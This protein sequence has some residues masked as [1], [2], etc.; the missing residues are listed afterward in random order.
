MAPS[1]VAWDS[2]DL[3]LF[4]INFSFCGFV[5]FV[6]WSWSR[7][8]SNFKAHLAICC[9]LSGI[10]TSIEILLLWRSLKLSLIWNRLLYW[11]QLI[12]LWLSVTN[13]Q[14]WP[15]GTYC[16]HFHFLVPIKPAG[17][18]C[19]LLMKC[20]TNTHI[21]S[22]LNYLTVMCNHSLICYYTW[23]GTTCDHS[24]C[25]IYILYPFVSFEL[26]YCICH[27]E[28]LLGLDSCHQ[29]LLVKGETLIL[30]MIFLCLVWT[31]HKSFFF[32]L[33]SINN[34]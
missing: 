12:P 19:V 22:F 8:C 29:R 2:V 10:K 1:T 27:L 24:I 6:D 4:R 3:I 20:M 5:S 15:H 34:T 28:I 7:S 26:L 21:Q 11:S 23:Y 14:H 31:K 13:L 16:A 32:Y 17:F 18:V 9:E 30:E 25:T 33:V